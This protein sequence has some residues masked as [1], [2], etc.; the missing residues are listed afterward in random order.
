MRIFFGQIIAL[1]ILF[2]IFAPIERIFALHKEQKTFRKGWRTDILHFLFNRF[3]IDVG[4][5]IVIVILAV[6]FRS[7]INSE[8]QNAVAAQPF[9]LQ[10]FEAFLIVNVCG[11][12]AH[13]LCSHNSVFV[14][15]SRRPSQFGK[16]GLARVCATSSA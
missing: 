10:F 1:F 14:E 11:Y 2:I 8:F 6:L 7:M 5:F 12:F 3:L 13:R 16:S 4:S 9:L 15:I